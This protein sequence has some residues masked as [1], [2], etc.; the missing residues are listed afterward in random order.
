[1]SPWLLLG[2]ASAQDV[3]SGGDTPPLD[4]QLFRPTLTGGRTVWVD[5]VGTSADPGFG[6]R[7]LLHYTNDPLVYRAADGEVT[8]LVTDVFQLDLLGQVAVGPVRLG[9]DLPVVLLEDGIAGRGA[10]LGNVQVEA[11]G[12]LFD[13]EHAPF[14]LAIA[15]RAFIPTSNADNALVNRDLAGELSLIA[16]RDFGPARLALNLGTG[17]GPDVSLENVRLDDWFI[18]RAAVSTALNEHA[19][20]ALETNARLPYSAPLAEPGAAVIEWF[21]S[22]THALGRGLVGRVGGGSG[23]TSGVGSPDLRLLVGV[24][25]SPAAAPPAPLD[26]DGDG[27][28]DTA[29]AC[30]DVA[31]DVDGF[32]DI[33]GCPDPDNDG[34]GIVDLSDGCAND[35]EDRDQVVDSDG[36][37]EPESPITVRVIDPSGKLVDVARTTVQGPGVE[38][39][40][41]AEERLELAPGAYAVTATAPGFAPGKRVIDVADGAAEVVLTLEP[42]ADT[43]IVVTKDRI[44]L[45]ETVRFQTSK[46]VI[47]PESFA[48]LD[49][50]VAVLK[51]YPQIA[52]LRVSGHTDSRGSE[53]DNLKLSTARA[54][55]VRQYLVDHG[56][57]ADRLV[58]EGFGESKP[59][60]PAETA[61]AWAKNRRV[62]LTVDQWAD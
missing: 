3:V 27:V 6:G 9:L 54:A 40:G 26:T 49:Q 51:D 22:G 33:D 35:P 45:K 30:V 25:W 57:A 42:L 12:L 28:V 17:S 23:L 7:A 39:S 20:L 8:G 4:A 16:D 18:G 61:D 56:I 52:K 43:K 36:C 13:R 58:S 48:L 29:D 60:D 34:D 10:A 55:A 38:R 5:E 50:V 62:D 19:T 44:E 2:V 31:E 1:M 11:R 37:P 53:A 32:G 59:L 46:A 47:L 14:G 41:G 24:G 15:G 21:A